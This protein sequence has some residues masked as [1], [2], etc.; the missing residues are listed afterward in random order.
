LAYCQPFFYAWVRKRVRTAKPS[1]SRPGRVN[2]PSLSASD[3]GLA[4]SQ[5]FFCTR[6]SVGS[7]GEALVIPSRTGEQSLSP[8]SL[9]EVQI[10]EKNQRLFLLLH[11]RLLW[12][13]FIRSRPVMADKYRN[14]WL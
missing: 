12:L 6:T 8:P 14:D 10:K 5:P 7:N 11:L 1:W 13:C 2:N 9:A 4:Y 3:L